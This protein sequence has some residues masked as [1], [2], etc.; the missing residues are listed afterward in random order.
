[1]LLFSH[2]F[3]ISQL[4]L[5]K[6]EECRISIFFFKYFI[7]SFPRFDSDFIAVKMSFHQTSAKPRS[8]KCRHFYFLFDT[9]NYC[10]MCS[11]NF[12]EEQ[13]IKI[14]ERSR[15]VRKQNVLDLCNASKDD[16][17]D[18]LGMTWRRFLALKQTLRVLLIYFLLLHASN[19]YISSLCL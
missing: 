8:S 13:Q 11:A 7:V 6:F 15:Y 12:I 14:K 1:M 10:P 3:F 4:I 19:P 18:L 5:T 17:L 2:L 9:H 16:D